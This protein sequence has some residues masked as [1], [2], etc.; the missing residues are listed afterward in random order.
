MHSGRL[1]C[2]EFSRASRTD[3]TAARHSNWFKPISRLF[4]AHHEHL[5]RHDGA[6]D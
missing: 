3:M 1:Q 5:N 4:D 2:V 6:S